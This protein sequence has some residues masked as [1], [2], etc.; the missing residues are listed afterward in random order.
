MISYG[1]RREK[2]CLRRFANNN[3]ADQ[4]AHLGSLISPFVIHFSKSS[5]CKL[6]TDEISPEET[7][8]SL[9]ISETPKTGFVVSRPIY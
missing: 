2:T 3:G 7:G 1:P 8:L 9:V 5:I 6:A 4:P